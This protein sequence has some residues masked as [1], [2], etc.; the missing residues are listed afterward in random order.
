MKNDS[1]AKH[2]TLSYGMRLDPGTGAEQEHPHVSVRLPN[3][4]NGQMALHVIN[5]TLEEIKAHT[6]E[7]IEAFF[8][9]LEEQGFPDQA[10][11]NGNVSNGSK[12]FV[13]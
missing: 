4:D 12:A 13:R 3:G 2:Y 5:G 9:I 8:E 7:S 11:G 10:P 6:R 1:T